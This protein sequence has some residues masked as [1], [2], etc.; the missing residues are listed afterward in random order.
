MT[1]IPDSID[2][3]LKDWMVSPDAMRWQ[4]PTEAAAAPDELD[5]AGMPDQLLGAVRTQLRNLAEIARQYAPE[6]RRLAQTLER[7]EDDRHAED[8]AMR[9]A[10]RSRQMARRRKG[11]RG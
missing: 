9:T 7:A 1:G 8:R 6:L 3:A 4:P 2:S 10:Y 5:I 11:R